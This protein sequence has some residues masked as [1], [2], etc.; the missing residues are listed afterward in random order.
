MPFQRQR[1]SVRRMLIVNQARNEFFSAV[2][3]SSRSLHVAHL[4]KAEIAS[5]L[6]GE[7]CSNANRELASA[8][9]TVSQNSVIDA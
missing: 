9:A 1:Q 4:C 2:S 5:G 7:A 6:Q 8:S 3:A